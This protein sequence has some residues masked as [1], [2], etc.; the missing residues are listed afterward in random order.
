MTLKTNESI[1]YV[2]KYIHRYAMKAYL[3]YKGKIIGKE[4]EYQWQEQAPQLG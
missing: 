4:E 1:Q 3:A 2:C